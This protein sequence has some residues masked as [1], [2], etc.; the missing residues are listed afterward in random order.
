MLYGPRGVSSRRIVGIPRT[1]LRSASLHPP[2]RVALVAD[3]QSP[4]TI[5][6]SSFRDDAAHAAS[7]SSVGQ[8]VLPRPLLEMLNL[9]EQ[10]VVYMRLRQRELGIEVMSPRQGVTQS[11]SRYLVPKR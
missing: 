7:I 1:L 4:E 11:A 3:A 8:L 9:D 10:K 2:T 6:I 5:V